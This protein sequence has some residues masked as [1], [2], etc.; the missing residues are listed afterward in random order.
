MQMTSTA[1]NLQSSYGVLV[2]CNKCGG[3]HDMGISIVIAD[4]PLDKQSVGDLY[5]GKT[6]P[7]NLADLSNNSVTCPTTGR[8]STQKN[9]YQIFLVPAKR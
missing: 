5:R 2:S 8:Q 7:K 4:G 1:K 3:A 9:N 6:V